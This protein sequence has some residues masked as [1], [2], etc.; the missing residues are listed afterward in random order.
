MEIVDTITIMTIPLWEII[1]T[2]V[3][4]L[5]F[6][7]CL[8]SDNDMSDIPAYIGIPCFILSVIMFFVFIVG[9]AYTVPDHE[10]YV[11]R[12][13]DMPAVEFARDWEVTKE[14]KYTDVIQVKKRSGGL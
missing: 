2:A 10:E 13:T 8:V 3:L 5:V 9:Q 1:V 6:V 14:Y 12:I 7:G 11:V 4:F